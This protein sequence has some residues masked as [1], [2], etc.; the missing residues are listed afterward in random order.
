MI[1]MKLISEFPNYCI[2]KDG[3]VWSKKRKD[4]RGQTVGG[5]WL[6]PIKWKST[7][8]LTYLVVR[9]YHQKEG[10]TD[11]QIS[12]LVLETYKRKR[13]KGCVCRHLDGNSHNNHLSNL[14]WGTPRENNLDV[15]RHGRHRRLGNRKLSESDVRFVT[16]MC[17]TKLFIQ[18]EIADY[19]GVC[20]ATINHI[21]TK[22]NWRHLW[23]T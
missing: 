2:T 23:A 14:C 7:G 21:I 8:D 10:W 17:R 6:K 11:K 15:I 5:K 4:T 20:Q 12:H 13:P 18:Q 9:L 1:E 3:R 22:R 19:F 16:Y